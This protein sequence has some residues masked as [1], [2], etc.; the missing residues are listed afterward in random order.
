MTLTN[1]MVGLPAMLLCLLVQVV[2][3]FWCVRHYVRQVR[4]R[5]EEGFWLGVRP[6]LVAMLALML[7]N[8]LQIALWGGLFVYLGEFTEAY[9]AIYHSAVNFTSL[10]YGDIVMSKT[11]KLLGPLE[12]ANGVLM[13]GMSAAA[14]MAILQ[15]LIKTY[16]ATHRPNGGA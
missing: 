11:W 15:H 12:A 7:G 3:A 13:L 5:H 2:V 10:G 1:F 8:L 9:D 14:L 16:A 4:H 6:L